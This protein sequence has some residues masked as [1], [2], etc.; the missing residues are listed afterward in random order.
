[1]SGRQ[2]FLLIGVDAPRPGT[3]VT[4]GGVLSGRGYAFGD[5]AVARIEVKLG[6][7]RLT[8]ADYGLARPELAPSFPHFAQAGFAGF[9][10][11][12]SVPEQGVAP[13]TPLSLVFHTEDG[14][15]HR[16]VVA[17]D[18]VHAA[19]G[20]AG[21]EAEALLP[22]IRLALETCRL[23]GENRLV[24]RGY[25]LARRELT[26]LELYLNAERLP[27]PEMGLSRP[28]MGR[29]HAAY[30]DAA[31]SGFR[32][33]HVLDRAAEPGDAVRVVA[34][35]EGHR[36]QVIAPLLRAGEAS[37]W[38]RADAVT[39]CCE[40][41]RLEAG[42]IFHVSGWAVGDVATRAIEVMDGETSL[43]LAEIGLERPDIGN[44]FP[45][46]P[47]ARQ[48]GFRFSGR[49]RRG[50]QTLA[51]RRI[52]EA[53]AETR[54]RLPVPGAARPGRD[55][56]A[57]GGAGAPV[58]PM[59][60]VETP[61][62]RAAGL[63]AEWRGTLSVT[64]WALVPDTADRVASVEIWA[65]ERRLAVAHHGLRREELAVHYPELPA[66]LTAGFAALLPPGL[67]KPGE[68]VLRVVARGE[69]GGV[70]EQAL[71]VVLTPDDDRR[72]GRPLP[73]VP[74][75]ETLLRRQIFARLGM[76]PRFCVLIRRPGRAGLAG[77]GATLRSLARQ[78]CPDWRAIV[79]CRDEAERLLLARCLETLPLLAPRVVGMTAAAEAAAIDWPDATPGVEDFLAIA[80]AGDR[81]GA[82][83][84]SVL[85]LEA[86][87]RGADFVY[88][89]ERA[90]D[91]ANDLAR[92]FA[93]PGWSPTL[94]TGFNYI[95]RAWCAT[96]AL[97][98]AAGVD[99]GSVEQLGEYDAVL[100]LTEAARMVAHVPAFLA[101]RVGPIIETAAREQAALARAAR[102]RAVPARVREAPV[103]GAFVLLPAPPRAARVSVIIPTKGARGLIRDCL[104]RLR[105]LAPAARGGATLEIIVLDGMDEAAETL[106]DFV[107]AH[108]DTVIRLE[109]P[110][111]WSRAN[112]VGARAARGAFLLFLNDDVLPLDDAW[113]PALLGRAAEKGVGAVGPKLLYP[114]GTVQHAGMFLHG[115]EGIHAFRCAPGDAPGPFGLASLAQE[116]SAVTGACLM[117]R[118][119]V[120][121]RLGG[122]D[123]AHDLIKNDLDYCLRLGQAGLRVVYAAEARLTHHEMASRVA[124]PD[125]HDAAAFAARWTLTMAAGD[126]LR[127]PMLAAG[128]AYRPE[129][130]P[131]EWLVPGGKL[132]SREA[133]RAVLVV[134]LD[135]IGDM[136]TALPALLRLR[137]AFPAARLHLLAQ[138]DVAALA[139]KA[140]AVDTVVPFQFFAGRA[141]SGARPIA[142]GEYETLAARLRPHGFDLAVDLRTHPDTRPIL[143]L[144][145]APVL[146]GFDRD[147]A[148]PWL[149]IA[150]EWEGDVPL[151]AKRSHIGGS[152]M[153]LAAAVEAACGEAD[154]PPPPQP[155]RPARI[156]VHA[157]AGNALKQWPEAH[158]VA[159]IRLLLANHAAEIV[160]IGG[161]EEA[162]LAAR[163]LA[164]LGETDRVRSMVG[165]ARLEALPGL[166]RGG[167]LFVG[168]DSG[169]KHMAAALGVP[170]IGIHAAHVDAAEW[171]P[172]GPRGLAL[173]RRMRCGPCYISQE[174]DCPRQ[175]ACLREMN[176]AQVYRACRTLL[177][178]SLPPAG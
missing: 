86:A 6:E 178:L 77:L 81:F 3:R 16:R 12:A 118:R 20:E 5:A 37:Q 108:A 25:A 159:L 133:V 103:P 1:M 155:S 94:L 96:R 47:G 26:A 82:D 35:A 171:G 156:F 53:G 112:N 105:A 170:T 43:G 98:T 135:H 66:A 84:F 174:T 15:E 69:R 137:R 175:V 80:R 129:P 158:F 99:A 168:N 19:K 68:H 148:F 160:L 127:N 121:E 2:G 92:P 134:K 76:T 11:S 104:S 113:L 167:A 32:L 9:A 109:G 71:R 78:D 54:L 136:V 8:F 88:A 24:L 23:D 91:A 10:F 176:P 154:L 75:A 122:F 131:V 51:L 169:P 62:A 153:R 87:V 41:A 34:R 146:A 73:F 22:P 55:G 143:K 85:A 30:K 144:S 83:A 172:A 38:L 100:R 106:R 120:F 13:D 132:L 61:A 70:R 110:F 140:G 29:R 49:L 89:D 150:V 138:P 145:G 93:K 56:D 125:S 130:E 141:G 72:I 107:R 177:A 48:A 44:R 90:H 42:R 147:G 128:E 102:R 101:E 57:A 17:L 79:L 59:L 97:V 165:I 67:M 4:R 161:T 64:G 33:V 40:T 45:R 173:R 152:L 119:R 18:W 28:E 74:L 7:T 151:R 142:P 162:A 58:A 27:A 31:K 95:G 36:R 139:V 149:D 46:L 117:T 164:A 111:N 39:L 65:D 157:G 166:L 126:G 124:L 114:D 115:A 52:D 14:R 50:T 123:E 116:V 63:V 60:M 163:L 21:G